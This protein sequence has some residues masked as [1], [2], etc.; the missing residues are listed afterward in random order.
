MWPTQRVVSRAECS[1]DERT[2]RG[3]QDE[4]PQAGID[5]TD[6][7]CG[8]SSPRCPRHDRS[9]AEGIAPSGKR[10]MARGGR[11]RQRPCPPGSP[12]RGRSQINGRDDEREPRTGQMI[13]AWVPVC[14]WRSRCVLSRLL[15]TFSGPR[16]GGRVFQVARPSRCRYRIT[17]RPTV[18]ITKSG[19]RFPV[20]RPKLSPGSFPG[21]RSRHPL[22]E[23]AGSGS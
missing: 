6:A 22:P 17:G 13:V 12:M 18:G 20:R 23:A 4:P 1:S 2:S 15:L 14:S 9:M 19:S 8:S 10:A 7:A 5:A 21:V 3:R 16:L 11:T